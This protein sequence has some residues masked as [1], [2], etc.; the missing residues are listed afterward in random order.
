MKKQQFAID[1]ELN[2]HKVIRA[3]SKCQ[4]HGK[5][6]VYAR[7]DFHFDWACQMTIYIKLFEI[8]REMPLKIV[9]RRSKLLGFYEFQEDS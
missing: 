1:C 6:Y 2:L 3:Q 7:K 4:R 9:L 8:N 5:Q